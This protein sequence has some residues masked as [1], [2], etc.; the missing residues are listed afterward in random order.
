MNLT[1]KNCC[2]KYEFI[3]LFQFDIVEINHCLRLD[4]T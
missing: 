2:L 3:H 4:T 1:I